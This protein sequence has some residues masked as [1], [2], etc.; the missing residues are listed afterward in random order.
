MNI[1]NSSALNNDVKCYSFTL[2]LSGVDELTDDVMNALF[3]AGCDD[4]TPFVRAKTFYLGFDREAHAL[5]EAIQTA[6][7]DA[8]KTGLEVVRVVPPEGDVIDTFNKLLQ[9]KRILT[10]ELWTSLD[11]SSEIDRSKASVLKGIESF[12][13]SLLQ[14]LEDVDEG[15]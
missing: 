5:S 14:E 15:S 12:A 4:A 2:V 6:I 1:Q 8:Q 9:A 11:E 10:Q 7:D 13:H 3:E